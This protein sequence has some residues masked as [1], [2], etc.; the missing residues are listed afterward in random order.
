GKTLGRAKDTTN[1]AIIHRV[2]NK[3]V[4]VLPDGAIN[5]SLD[6]SIVYDRAEQLIAVLPK[7]MTSTGMVSVEPGGAVVMMS[8]RSAETNFHNRASFTK[9]DWRSELSG[10]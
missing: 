9:V 5:P 7:E 4:S 1:R 2:V 8:G 6:E 3:A 10:F